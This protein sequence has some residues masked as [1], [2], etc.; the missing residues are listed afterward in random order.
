MSP[1]TPLTHWTHPTRDSINLLSVSSHG[2]FYETR[3]QRVHASLRHAATTAYRLHVND[4]RRTRA[5]R[6]RVFEPNAARELKGRD[7]N[8]SELPPKHRP[9]GSGDRSRC[10]VAP[11][12]SISSP[13]EILMRAHTRTIPS[14]SGFRG[15]KGLG[16]PGS[17]GE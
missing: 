16:V 2:D 14:C 4:G 7:A 10:C 13:T 15:C 8:G 3:V 12:S 5:G 11:T 9:A 6:H 17:D 1:E